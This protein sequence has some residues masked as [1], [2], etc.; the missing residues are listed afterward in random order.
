MPPRF[1][2]HRRFAAAVALSLLAHVLVSAS[3]GPSWSRRGPAQTATLVSPVS[4]R[5]VFSDPQPPAA[6]ERPA[7]E[8]ARIAAPRN[9]Q[10]QRRE[11]APSPAS[12]TAEPI[13]AQGIDIP[14]PTYYPARRLDVYPTLAS[15][16]D[17]S[18]FEAATSSNIKARVL[19]LVLIDAAGNVDDVSIAESG[20][21]EELEHAARRAFLAARFT[22]ARKNGRAVKSQVLI[23]VNYGSEIA[24]RSD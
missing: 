3:L 2:S 24:A 12:R 4:A 22:P 13:A 5:L 6:E 8:P 10:P 15:E 20:A 23:E 17:R 14:D 11:V 16:L 1:H 18:Y 9:V 7:P 21:A 19:L